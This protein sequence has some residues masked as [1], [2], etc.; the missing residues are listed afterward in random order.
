MK[1]DDLHNRD[2]MQLCKSSVTYLL[3]PNEIC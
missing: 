1:R 2:N 3:K